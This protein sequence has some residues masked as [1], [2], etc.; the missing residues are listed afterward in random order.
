MK[1]EYTLEG[2]KDKDGKLKSKPVSNIARIGRAT[3]TDDEDLDFQ[4]IVYYLAGVGASSEDSWLAKTYQGMSGLGLVQNVREAYGFLCNNYDYGDEI[5]ITGFS[6]GAFT[7]RSVAGM[8]GKV[9]ILTKK[10]LE[11]FYEAFDFY[12]DS[13]NKTKWGPKLQSPVS[14]EVS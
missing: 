11:L 3:L 7:A 5:Y 9:G 13:D 4:Q 6:R 10:G 12:E 8:V 14:E 2:H 1:S